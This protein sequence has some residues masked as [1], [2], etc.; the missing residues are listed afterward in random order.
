M[1]EIAIELAFQNLQE[2]RERKMSST[3]RRRSV[4]DV[5]QEQQDRQRLETI[6]HTTLLRSTINDRTRQRRTAVSE[7]TTDERVFVEKSVKN[8]RRMSEGCMVGF[9]WGQRVK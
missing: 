9:V 2:N 3:M 8:F 1:E 6:R 4:A 5:R 7:K